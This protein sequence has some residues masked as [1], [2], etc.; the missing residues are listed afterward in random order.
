MRNTH[1]TTDEHHTDQIMIYMTLAEGKSSIICDKLSLHSQTMIEL[2]RIFIPDV[3]IKVEEICEGKG[4]RIEI[5]G[6]GYHN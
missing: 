4:T 3:D 2:I 1:I 6:I 5:N